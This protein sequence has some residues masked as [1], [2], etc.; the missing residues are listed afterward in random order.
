MSS[1][2]ASDPLRPFPG[3]GS[4]AKRS[5]RRSG[6]QHLK[7]RRSRSAFEAVSLRKESRAGSQ[8]HPAAAPDVWDRERP[9]TPVPGDGAPGA[10]LLRGAGR[11]TLL[12]TVPRLKT[13]GRVA[14]SRLS[15]SDLGATVKRP[16]R[17]AA[18]RRSSTFL[19]PGH[20]IRN[21]AHRPCPVGLQH[22]HPRKRRPATPSPHPRRR[23]AWCGLV[24]ALVQLGA[25]TAHQ[26]PRCVT[27]VTSG[28][29]M[30]RGRS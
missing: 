6:I 16:E 5:G 17:L 22:R 2:D 9:Q 27:G 15:R 4:A 1:R 24:L 21:P 26:W 28:V 12:L 20:A 10:R 25:A 30:E 19:I 23:I 29:V 11:L 18:E 14:R 3:Q 8:S 13:T 7:P